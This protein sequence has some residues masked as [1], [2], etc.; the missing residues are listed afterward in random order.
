MQFE[1]Y[2]KLKHPTPYV[3]RLAGKGKE[4]LYYGSSHRA[5]PEDPMFVDIEKRFSEFDPDTA[6]YE[7]ETG[8]VT[9]RSKEEAIRSGGEAEFVAFLCSQHHIK[10]L[11]AT[12][13]PPKEAELLT[14]EFS[15][16]EV[17]LYFVARGLGYRFR[18]GKKI[19]RD[20]LEKGL[21]WYKKIL[22][23]KGFV[24][25]LESLGKIHRQIVGRGLDLKDEGFWRD[26]S[27]PTK[28]ISVLN[29]IVRRSGD[30]RDEFTVNF[31]RGI[32]KSYNRVFVVMGSSHA[33]R[34]EPHLRKLIEG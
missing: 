25:S 26:A 15:K 6:L 31:I 33:R 9:A 2:R 8:P 34:Q 20:F 28:D 21:S 4:L 23:W 29:E 27:N 14:R 16:E 22:G 32:L 19:T 10:A 7:G 11:S 17:F 12:L 30:L 5:D 1:D 13:P 3:Y 18:V 24:F